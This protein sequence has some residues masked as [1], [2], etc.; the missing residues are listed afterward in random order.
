MLQRRA[1]DHLK[2]KPVNSKEVVQKGVKGDA[3][4]RSK[5]YL[6]VK[7]HGALSSLI[8]FDEKDRLTFLLS[9]I[10]ILSILIVSILILLLCSQWS[11]LCVVLND[12]FHFP[13]CEYDFDINGL[14]KHVT[15]TSFN[16]LYHSW[17]LRYLFIFFTNAADLYITY[18][19]V[20][21]LR[22][23]NT[24]DRNFSR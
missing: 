23:M 14:N 12:I 24:N 7:I 11:S 8:E 20:D 2:K 9:V 5:I 19:H 6:D 1:R 16:F 3:R 18:M 13:F 4:A 15:A 22:E 17:P 21:T 10:F